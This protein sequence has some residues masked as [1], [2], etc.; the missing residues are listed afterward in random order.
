LRTRE[1][2]KGGTHERIFGGS[3]VVD[4]AIVISFLTFLLTPPT[5]LCGDFK[6]SGCMFADERRRRSRYGGEDW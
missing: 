6:F 2:A 4:Q 3:A 1:I 5:R